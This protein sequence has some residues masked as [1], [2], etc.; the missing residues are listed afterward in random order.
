M[1]ETLEMTNTHISDM[2]H[3]YTTE[4]AIYYDSSLCTECRGCQA[5]CKCWNLLPSPITKNEDGSSRS[6][7]APSKANPYIG[8]YQNPPDLNGDTR[9]IMRVNEYDNPD[10]QKGLSL[11]FSRRACEHCTDA[12][13]VRMCPTGCLHHNEVTGM[14]EVSVDK[15][16]ACHYCITGCPF[17]VPQYRNDG[18]LGAKGVIEKCDGCAT[19]VANGLKPACVTTCQPE[20]LDFGPRDEMVAKAQARVEKLKERGFTDAYAYGVNEMEGLHVIHVLKYGIEKHEFRRDPTL[21]PVVP[22]SEVAKPLTGLGIGL[23][24]A[25][26]AASFVRGIGYKKHELHYDEQSGV[27][28]SDGKPVETFDPEEVRE[29][30]KHNNHV[31]K[32]SRRFADGWDEDRAAAAA[33][34]GASVPAQEDSTA[35]G[36]DSTSSTEGDE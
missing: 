21:S 20:A 3:I 36:A 11:V 23:T 35:A 1:A 6:I 33:A 19:R 22:L 28:Y 4:C 12:G 25:G 8:T 32:V 2:E 9:L 24:V 13:C 17:G 16:I 15:C 31:A 18:H 29:S 26:L 34:A 10:S 27:Q 30:E 7:N 5:A 14:V